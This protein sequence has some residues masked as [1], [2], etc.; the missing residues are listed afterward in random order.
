MPLWADIRRR[1]RRAVHATFAQAATYTP[2]G[3]APVPVAVR[4]HTRVQRQGDLDPGGYAEVFEDVNRIV[5]LRSDVMPAAKG[6]VRFADG[7]AYWIVN[8]LPSDDGTLAVCEVQPRGL[9]P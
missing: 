5:F 3:G 9:T 1:A 6:L 2:Y 7:R 4:L 8:V